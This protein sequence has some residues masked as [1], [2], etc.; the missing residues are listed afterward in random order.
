LAGVLVLLPDVTCARLSTE[1][2]PLDGVIT[3]T[4]ELDKQRALQ[5]QKIKDIKAQLDA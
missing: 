4:K 3:Q 2:F 1:V 5:Q